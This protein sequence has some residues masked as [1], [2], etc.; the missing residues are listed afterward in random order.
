MKVFVTSYL[1][2]GWVSATACVWR[3]DMTCWSALALLFSEHHPMSYLAAPQINIFKCK[4]QNPSSRIPTWKNP[5][6]KSGLKQPPSDL[7]R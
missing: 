1:F 3:S 7:L 5:D 6:L 4:L 2:R